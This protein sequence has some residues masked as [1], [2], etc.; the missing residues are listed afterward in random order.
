MKI[1]QDM[2]KNDS[3][4]WLYHGGKTKDRPADLGYFMGFRITQ[5]YYRRAPDKT[6]AVI[7]ILNIKDFNKFV[8]DSG[9][10]EEKK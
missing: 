5:A 3:T 4:N 2:K 7:N 1:L 10:F 9:Y 8:Q 6:Q